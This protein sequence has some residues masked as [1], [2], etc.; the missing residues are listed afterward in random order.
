MRLIIAGSR[1]F[2]RYGILENAIF[3]SGFKD[4]TSIV[5]GG[6]KGADYYGELYAKNNDIPVIIYKADWDKYGPSAGPKR[7]EL[8]AHNADA[9]IALWDGKSKGTKHMID[10]AAKCGLKIYV[11]KF[12]SIYVRNIKEHT[13]GYYIGRG[14]YGYSESILHNPFKITKEIERKT[15]LEKYEN[16]LLE[17]INSNIIIKNEI[18]KLYK[19]SL[20]KDLNLLCWCHPLRCHGDIIKKILDYRHLEEKGIESILY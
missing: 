4:I 18:D 1:T 2:D 12:F 11:K 13:T 9:L 8:M 20:E 16:Y 5:S 7:N 15:V 19:Q 17:K 10:Y 14:C 6:A 3:E